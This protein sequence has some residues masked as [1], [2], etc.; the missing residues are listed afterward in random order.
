[1]L[2]HLR[3]TGRRQNRADR[4]SGAEPV[5]HGARLAL[6]RSRVDPADG[7]RHDPPHCSPAPWGRS[8]M[9]QAL[10]LTAVAAYAFLHAPLLILAVFSVNASKFTIWQGL[11]LHWYR[12]AFDD[13]QLTDAAFNSLVIALASTL[14][15][16]AIGTLSAYGLW[17]RTSA[18]LA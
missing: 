8:V 10:G 15:S 3:F 12:A 4:K 6:R 14:V 11:S 18:W 13:A 9:K 5:H 1:H 16:T 17:K 7:S 2:P